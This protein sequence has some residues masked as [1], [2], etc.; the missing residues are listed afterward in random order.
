MSDVDLFNLTD[1]SDT[2]FQ[3]NKE[4]SRLDL[5]VELFKLKGDRTLT[6]QELL[7]AMYRKYGKEMTT[8]NLSNICCELVIVTGKPPC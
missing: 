3:F 7:V 1:T 4:V 2:P 5:V 8:S 6:N